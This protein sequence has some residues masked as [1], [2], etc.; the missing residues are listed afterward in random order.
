MKP[1]TLFSFSFF[2]SKNKNKKWLA[3][4]ALMMACEKKLENQRA[5]KG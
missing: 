4:R 2:F 5:G 3:G 1:K